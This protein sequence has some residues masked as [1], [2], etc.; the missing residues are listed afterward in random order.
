MTKITPDLE[1]LVQRPLKHLERDQHFI[2]VIVN[3][4]G[5]SFPLEHACGPCV[6]RLPPT[7]LSAFVSKP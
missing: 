3:K 5:H 7:S 4:K 1:L 6:H 2:G